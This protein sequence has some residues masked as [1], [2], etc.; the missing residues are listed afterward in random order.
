VVAAVVLIAAVAVGLFLALRGDDDPAPAADATAASTTRASSSSSSSSPSSSSSSA[1]PS[2]GTEDVPAGQPP[3][4]LGDQPE[5]DALAESCFGED[6][7]ACD[8]LYVQSDVGSEYE[9]YGE[10]CGGRNEPVFGGCELR[11]TG[12]GGGAGGIPADLPPAQPA[13]TGADSDVQ[14][15]ADG[16]EQGIVAFCDLLQLAA[17][18]DPALQPYADYGATCGGRNE[19]VDSCI[20]RYPG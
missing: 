15:V 16:C 11:Y 12:T 4:A 19:P 7:V 5:L 6:W 2:G 3:G 10:T 9:S 8:D 20:D 18:S 13:P 17:L 14:S 1:P